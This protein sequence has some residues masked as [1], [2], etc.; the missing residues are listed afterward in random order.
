MNEDGGDEDDG[1]GRQTMGERRDDDTS[2]D[3]ARGNEDEGDG[4]DGEQRWMMME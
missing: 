2:N 1:E 3:R 4:D